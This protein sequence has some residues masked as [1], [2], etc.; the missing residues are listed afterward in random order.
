MHQL[1]FY[2]MTEHVLKGV[3]TDKRH[4]NIVLLAPK[5]FL[6]DGVYR[7]APVRFSGLHP[8]FGAGPSWIFRAHAFISET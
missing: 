1:S 4:E 8:K 3:L 6:E 5:N 7:P 2:L